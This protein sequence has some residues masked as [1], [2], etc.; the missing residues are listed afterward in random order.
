[1]K[2]TSSKSKVAQM[3][4]DAYDVIKSE[5]DKLSPIRKFVF[6]TIFSRIFDIFSS[7]YSE[8]E[9]S[10]AVNSLEK[11]GSEHINP[12]DYLNY[13]KAMELLHMGNNRAGF[14]ELMRKH[15]IKNRIVN[16]VHIGFPKAELLALKKELEVEV[17]K[18]EKK[19]NIKKDREFR[20]SKFC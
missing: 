14:S 4:A 9:L 8:E 10:L 19:E 13:D 2:S 3:K 1:M 7:D 17:K 11:V 15:G 16:N 20:K 12:N 18:R 5:I 6:E